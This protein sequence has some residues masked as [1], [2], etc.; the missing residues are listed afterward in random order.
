MSFSSKVKGE[1]ARYS[2]ISKS[3]A[4]AE[5]SAIMKVSGT[6]AFSG[7]GLSFRIATENPSSARV[8]FTLLKEF[9][10]IHSKLMMKKSN[11]LKKNNI[12]MVIIDEDMGVRKL[13][14]DTGIFKEID[15]VMSID[16]RIE[17]KHDKK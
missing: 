12:Y 2:D 13:L 8:I 3:E 7:K 16:Y 1:I 15:G 11:S 5:I 9:F 14:R 4:L 17:K 10:N 6:I